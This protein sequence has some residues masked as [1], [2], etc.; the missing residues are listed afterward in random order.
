MSTS[1]P[2]RLTAL[3]QPRAYPHPVNEVTLVETHVSWVLLT[4]EF[5]YKIKRP[6][7]FPFVDLRCLERRAYFCREE[8]RLNRRFAPQLYVDVC[9][10]TVTDGRAQI[11]GEGELI[12]HAIKMR[13]FPREDELDSLLVQGRVAP[14]EL[15][16]FGRELASIHS[17]LPV[18]EA[19]APWGDPRLVHT[20]MLRNFDECE[21]ASAAFDFASEVR[22]MLPELEQRLHAA[23]PWMSDRREDGRVRECHGDLH[24]GNI[25]RLESQLVAFDCMEFEPAFRWIDA[26]EEIAFLLA[27]LD[28]RGYSQYEQP[29]L[30]GYLARSGD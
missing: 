11:G 6:V 4:G 26:A 30:D 14:G 10:V 9:A 22:A 21:R 1:L 17:R 29:F 27:D 24:A 8:L 5:A 15:E 20:L 3:L 12:E 2:E 23:V 19:P 13:L 18:A 28:A 16:A 25:V 7:C